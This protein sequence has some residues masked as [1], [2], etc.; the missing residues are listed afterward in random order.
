M[1]GDIRL[2]R[3][4]FFFLDILY[5]CNPLYNFDTIG[6]NNVTNTQG[7]ITVTLYP[8]LLFLFSLCSCTYIA[9][10]WTTLQLV[11]VVVFFCFFDLGKKLKGGG[12]TVFFFFTQQQQQ[13]H[14]REKEQERERKRYIHTARQ[15]GH[16]IRLDARQS[17]FSFRY[18]PCEL[19]R[20]LDE[21]RYVQWETRHSSIHLAPPTLYTF[22]F[23]F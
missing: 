20:E 14:G 13:Q 4:A 12:R 5:V 3:G 8:L 10:S 11:L 6:K 23:N 17:A 2:S 9:E 15:G 22:F 21:L 19:S 16:I 7:L 1:P 18:R